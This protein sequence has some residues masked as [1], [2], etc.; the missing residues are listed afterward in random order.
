M[1]GGN[2]ADSFSGLFYLCGSYTIKNKLKKNACFAVYFWTLCQL[3]WGFLLMWSA[4][5]PSSPHFKSK[6]KV[7]CVMC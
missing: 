5:L 7:L 3:C 1:L 4:F 2:T 6:L